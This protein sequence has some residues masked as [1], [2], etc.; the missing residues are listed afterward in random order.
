ML[1]RGLINIVLLA[2]II[3]LIS[4][5][6][7]EADTEKNQ[8]LPKL[9]DLTANQVNLIKIEKLNEPAI[10]FHKNEQNKW[11]MTEPL[12]LPANQFRIETLLQVLANQDYQLIDSQKLSL[13]E[14]KLAP[15]NIKLTLNQW[16]ME[17][18]DSSPINNGQRY[19]QV[20]KQVYLMLDSV[21]H[22]LAD[23]AVIFV[24]LSPLGEEQKITEIQT[25]NYHL[26]A[27]E[28]QWIALQP[29]VDNADTSP[30]SLNLFIDNWQRLQAL[31]VEQYSAAP[32]QGIVTI[33]L[34]GQ[35]TPLEFHILA[36]EPNFIL[37]LPEKKVQYQLINEQMVKLLQLP[38]RQ[39]T[40]H[41]L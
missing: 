38:L 15:S 21:Y 7:Y 17:F 2:V 36:T 26:R 31:G 12:D 30:D 24:S 29:L 9:T 14:V 1:H 37:A 40:L 33:H 16:M 6:I 41:S 35:T 27:Q 25:P 39:K 19:V 5:I 22:F 34:K 18:G 8:S 23:D 3:S 28:G 4:F 11:V 13:S 10:L 32:S 20:N